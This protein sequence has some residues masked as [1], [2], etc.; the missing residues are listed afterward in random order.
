[1]NNHK[2]NKSTLLNNTAYVNLAAIVTSQ[3]FLIGCHEGTIK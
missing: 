1:M 3:L 2:N